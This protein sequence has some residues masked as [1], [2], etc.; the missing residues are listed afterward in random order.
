MTGTDLLCIA[1]TEI[2]VGTISEWAVKGLLA[3]VSVA[4]Q[5]V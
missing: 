2:V 3:L 1:I 4:V 5:R